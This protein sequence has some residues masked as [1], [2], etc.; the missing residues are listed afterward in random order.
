MGVRAIVFTVCLAAAAVASAACAEGVRP[1]A[2][3]PITE[4]AQTWMAEA[5]TPAYVCKRDLWIDADH[6]R[7]WTAYADGGGDKARPWKSLQDADSA[8]AGGKPVLK[9]GDCVNLAPG[10][11][12]MIQ[13]VQLTHGG[14]RNAPDGWLVIRSAT[15]RAAHLVAAGPLWGMIDIKAAYIILDGLDIDGANAT[16]TGEGICACGDASHHHIVVENSL[17]HGVGGSGVQLNDSEY[18]W[19]VGNEVWGNA[20]TNPYQGSGISTY[21]AQA[22]AGVTPSPADD[23]KFHIVIAGNTSHDNRTTYPCGPKPGCHTDGNGVIVDKTRNVDRKGGVPYTGRILVVG[24][25]VYGNGGGGIHLYLSEHVL[26]AGN[27]AIGNHLDADNAGT[28]RGELSNADSHSTAWIGNLGWAKAGPGVLAHNSGVLVGATGGKPAEL[29][30]TWAGNLTCGGDP[31]VYQS[32]PGLDP[33]KNRW[34]ADPD[35][36]RRI[37]AEATGSAQ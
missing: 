17:I 8:Q 18:F 28:W 27:V 31:S 5:H 9:A 14:E 11:Y 10:R 3:S 24:N 35:A 34:N 19:V 33:S 37:A 30:V 7:P 20:S 23:L 25:Y 15:P 13:G 36:C 12:E 21:Q 32:T 1:G 6:G 22:A 29:G 26:A 4:A 16:A 2:G